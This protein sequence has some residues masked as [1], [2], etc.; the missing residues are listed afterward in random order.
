MKCVKQVQYECSQGDLSQTKTIRIHN[1]VLKK[2]SD[3]G[4]TSFVYSSIGVRLLL[5]LA[6]A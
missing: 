5:A 1:I 3:L 6:I 2:S 4:F